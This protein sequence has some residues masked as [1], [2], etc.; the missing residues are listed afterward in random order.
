M[1]TG[2]GL[3]SVAIHALYGLEQIF[4]QGYT[5]GFCY[6]E[7]EIYRGV[8]E[9]SAA[10]GSLG[11]YLQI[12][13]VV[14]IGELRTASGYGCATALHQQL[15]TTDI[16]FSA[17]HHAIEL[18]RAQQIPTQAVGVTAILIQL[19]GLGGYELVECGCADIGSYG[20]LCGQRVVIS[21]NA[22]AGV[23]A[24][25]GTHTTRCGSLLRAIFSGVRGW[26]ALALAGGHCGAGQIR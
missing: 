9:T 19:I 6:F 18:C 17:A 21:T 4:D 26:R 16:G 3:L 20:G 10:Q 1:S 23:A 13:H 14:V 12:V 11:G 8:G 7:S 25:S 22:G 15:P 5:I 24:G 2:L